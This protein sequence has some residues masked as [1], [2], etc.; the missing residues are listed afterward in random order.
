M[1]RAGRVHQVR[2]AAE[3]LGP[4]EQLRAAEPPGQ[5]A[6]RVLRELQQ[7]PV[8]PLGARQLLLAH[9]RGRTARPAP[10]TTSA[11]TSDA[12]SGAHAASISKMPASWKA[13]SEA[14]TEYASPRFSTIS[15]GSREDSPSS[16]KR[17]SSCRAGQSS[18][19][20]GTVRKLMR[21]SV[22]DSSWVTTCRCGPGGRGRRRQRRCSRRPGAAGRRRAPPGR[23]PASCFT[24]PAAV[25]TMLP[26]T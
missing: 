26:V 20:S 16:R 22:W 9:R 10:G 18:W 12:R 5:L 11:T 14:C 2:P 6:R 8:P 15:K 23:A 17:R 1:G 21:N 24:R 25:T 13:S 4:A 7:H 3:G 19:C